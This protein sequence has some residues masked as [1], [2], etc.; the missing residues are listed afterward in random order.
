MGKLASVAG[1]EGKLAGALLGAAATQALGV[2]DVNSAINGITAAYNDLRSRLVRDFQATINGLGDA[3]ATINGD[4]GLQ[5]A[6]GDDLILAGIWTKLSPD[7]QAA[8]VASAAKRYDLSVWQTLTPGAWAAIQIA[9]DSDSFNYYCNM[10]S[11][12]QYGVNGREWTIAY[13]IGSTNTTGPG[14]GVSGA[15]RNQLF[16]TTQSAC[17]SIWDFGS[18]DLGVYYLDFFQGVNG[19]E[20]LPVWTCSAVFAYGSGWAT[21]CFPGRSVPRGQLGKPVTKRRLRAAL[22]RQLTPVGSAA[23]I[24]AILA[25]GSYVL[26]FLPPSPGMLVVSWHR[27][28]QLIATGKATFT[29][30]KLVKLKLKL[31]PAGRRLLRRAKRLPISAGLIFAPTRGAPT[32]VTSTFTLER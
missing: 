29:R 16:G 20:N 27:H 28:S 18:C 12:C 6:V 17:E 4:Y 5:T 8:A 25:H 21:A 32:S 3:R 2:P 23:R 10:L 13:G 24:E 22:R 11:Y 14:A 7:Q 1:P 9:N 19:W 15:L 30:L 31:T 26:S